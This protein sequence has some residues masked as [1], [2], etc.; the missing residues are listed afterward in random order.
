MNDS[1]K[2]ES[3]K[4]HERYVYIIVLF[5]AEWRERGIDVW[6]YLREQKKMGPEPPYGNPNAHTNGGCKN[7]AQAGSL[8]RLALPAVAEC[9]D[10]RI[11]HLPLADGHSS[12]DYRV[13]GIRNQ[14]VHIGGEVAA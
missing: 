3:N 5:L 2:G 11:Q 13:V 8:F 4:T 9:K 10:L 6:I 14:I 1:G 7:L 12:L